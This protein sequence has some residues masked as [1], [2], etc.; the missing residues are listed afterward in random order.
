MSSNKTVV[1]ESMEYSVGWG[2]E[3]CVCVYVERGVGA[4]RGYKRQQFDQ[5][6]SRLV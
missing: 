3:V 2:G 5:H 6:L 1:K 4:V